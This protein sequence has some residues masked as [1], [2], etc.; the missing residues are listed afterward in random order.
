M[1]AAGVARRLTTGERLFVWETPGTLTLFTDV[2]A[3]EIKARS[4]VLPGSEPD[5]P[6]SRG[7]A[8]FQTVTAISLLA[9]IGIALWRFGFGD[10][11]NI[12]WMELTAN[13]IAFAMI[14]PAWKLLKDFNAV[15]GEI[16]RQSVQTTGSAANV[17]D[18]AD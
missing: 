17:A 9:P 1:I 18:F 3:Q 16:M 5:E 12:K 14:L 2:A 6:R 15:T 10:P 13:A 8:F 11:S 7:A 4:V